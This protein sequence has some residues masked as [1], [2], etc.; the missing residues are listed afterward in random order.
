[1]TKAAISTVEKP[2]L[3]AACERKQGPPR[4]QGPGGANKAL[5]GKVPVWG[6]KK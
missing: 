3:Y 4:K 1:M 2:K 6:G 5:A